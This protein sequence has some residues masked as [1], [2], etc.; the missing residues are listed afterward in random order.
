MRKFILRIKFAGGSA[1]HKSSFEA[2]DMETA[3]K[4]G[5]D[6]A[7]KVSP[8]IPVVDFQVTARDY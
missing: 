4:C 2:P 5:Y 7:K 3:V 6:E 8:G 1:Y